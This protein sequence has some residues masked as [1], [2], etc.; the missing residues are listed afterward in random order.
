MLHHVHG[1]GEYLDHLS[2]DKGMLHHVHGYGEYLDHMSMAY[3]RNT[4][5]AGSVPTNDSFS[6]KVLRLGN[7]G[8][9]STLSAR[10][11]CTMCTA[12]ADIL[13]T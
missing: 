6:V 12:M 8:V 2:M 1:Y 7:F 9:H 11:C 10:A 4:V 3:A 13:T 5:R